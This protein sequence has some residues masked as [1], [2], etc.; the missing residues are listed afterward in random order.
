MVLKA[1]ALA[2]VATPPPAAAIGNPCTGQGNEPQ[3][4]A[5]RTYW[6]E[7]DTP[8]R[9]LHAQAQGVGGFHP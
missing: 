7:R 2:T 9:P 6:L 1:L 5:C 4:S 8:L 3:L